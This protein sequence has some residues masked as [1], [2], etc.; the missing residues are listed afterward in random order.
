M[1][2]D[3]KSVH[4]QLRFILPNKIGHVEMIADIHPDLVKSAI[5]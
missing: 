1:A 5:Q 3:K 4:G 2:R